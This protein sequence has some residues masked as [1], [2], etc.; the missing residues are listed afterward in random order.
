MFFQNNI[1]I[2]WL[3]WHFFDVPKD[4]LKA[5]RNFLLFNWNYFS[6]SLLG[7]TLFAHWRKYRYSYG[8]GFDYKRYFEVFTFN[9]MSRI[10]GAIIRLIFIFLGIVF[11]IF[12]FGAITI[13]FFLWLLSPAIL[14]AGLVLGLKFLLPAIIMTNLIPDLKL[15]I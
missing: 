11:E 7:K 14:L 15:L 4:I 2:L 3:Q 13:L 1:L 12:I 8:R 10:F 9:L 6:I 5:G